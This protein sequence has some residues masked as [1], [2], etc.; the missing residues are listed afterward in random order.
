MN[1]YVNLIAF[2]LVVVSDVLQDEPL[3]VLPTLACKE[4]TQV[5]CHEGGD[6]SPRLNNT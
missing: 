2:S 3:S 1:E 6:E 4:K 5:R